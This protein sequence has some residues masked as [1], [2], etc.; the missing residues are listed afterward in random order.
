MRWGAINNILYCSLFSF[1][2]CRLWGCRGV[3]G[4]GVAW[5]ESV[6]CLV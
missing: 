4:G 6:A 2:F 3:G 5:A 1:L